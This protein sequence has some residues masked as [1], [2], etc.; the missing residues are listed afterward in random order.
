MVGHL[1]LVLDVPG[2]IPACVEKISVSEHAF[3]GVICMDDT[4]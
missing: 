4:R 3:S 1:S 2:S